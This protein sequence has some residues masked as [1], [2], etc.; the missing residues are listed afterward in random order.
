M[1]VPL[2][3]LSRS[4]GVGDGELHHGGGQRGDQARE[5]EGIVGAKAQAGVHLGPYRRAGVRSDGSGARVR[6]LTDLHGQQI[7]SP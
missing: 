5:R 3:R 6:F 1:Y 4:L 2:T 7:G